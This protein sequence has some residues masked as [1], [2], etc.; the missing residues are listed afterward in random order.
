MTYA[1]IAQAMKDE[2]QEELRQEE[3]DHVLELWSDGEVT[4]TKCGSLYGQ[5][6]LHQ[7]A[8]PVLTE[9][10]TPPDADWD[11]MAEWFD[12]RKRQPKPWRVALPRERIWEL[13]RAM[14]E[15]QY[16]TQ[17]RNHDLHARVY[18]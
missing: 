5:R 1:D 17:I 7:M 2:H 18:S 12:E 8:G 14:I 13:R 10:L 11:R 4:M 6:S 9:Q 3:G 16:E 15:A